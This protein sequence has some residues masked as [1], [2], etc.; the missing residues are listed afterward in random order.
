MRREGSLDAKKN[1]RRPP[2]L[3]YA[4]DEAPPPVVTILNGIQHVALIAIFL[5]YPLLVFRV[6][7]LSVTL[8]ANLLAI[9]M[10]VLGIGT[11]LQAQTRGPLGSGYMCPSTFT[12]V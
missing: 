11:L 7:G 6:A 3:I 12:A 10:I 1:R 2:N 8:S 5:V 4:V 9:G